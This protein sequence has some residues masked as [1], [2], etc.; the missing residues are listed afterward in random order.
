M[1]QRKILSPEGPVFSLLDTVGRLIGLGLLWL[2]GC[3]PIVTATTST[4]ALYYAVMKSVRRGCGSAWQEFWSAYR[5]NLKRGIPITLALGLLGAV[6]TGNIRYL[7]Q[8]GQT[9]GTLLW[10]SVFL[11]AVLAAV[12]IYIGP[13]LSR[14]TLGAWRACQMA[15]VMALRF[16]YI[17]LALALGL[18]AL[19]LL[20]IYILPMPTALALPGLWCWTTTFLT[21]RAL[22]AYMP[23]KEENDD[24][25]Y[26]Q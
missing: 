23:P 17:T 10:G 21:E 24:S 1:S 20:Q 25:W 3:V 26:Y 13:V 12:A 2:L 9:G 19:V 11:L 15:F 22:R 5:S 4:A 18:T 14:F 7:W 16:W 6:L 8:S